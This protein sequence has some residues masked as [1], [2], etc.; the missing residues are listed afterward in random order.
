MENVGTVYNGQSSGSAFPEEIQKYLL[1]PKCTP[2]RNPESRN[3][4][5]ECCIKPELK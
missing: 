5:P 4:S 3:E 2:D 1:N